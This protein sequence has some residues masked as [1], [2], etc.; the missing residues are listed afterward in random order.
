MSH[1]KSLKE[2][3][4]YFLYEDDSLST[5]AAKFVLMALFAGGFAFAGAMFPG[6]LRVVGQYKGS[7]RYSKKQ[8]GNAIYNLKRRKMV[9]I[10]SESGGKIKVKLTK[11]GKEKIREFSFDNLS[12]AKPKKWDCKWR[13]V[14]FDIPTRRNQARN[15]LREKIKE[16]GFFQLQKSVWAHPYP[17]EDEILLVA[18]IFRVMP[19][20]EIITAEK[21]L[22]ERKIKNF[23]RL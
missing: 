21:I 4:E 20:V 18:E 9:E 19:F 13:V 2:K 16:L 22:H 8:I 10:V 17:C 14:I 11:E 3:I 23:F 15:A 6:V 12:I 7:R 5:T 1:S